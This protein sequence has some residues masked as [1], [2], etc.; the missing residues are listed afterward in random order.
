MTDPS[1]DIKLFISAEQLLDIAKAHLAKCGV[2][3]DSCQVA[4]LSTYFSGTNVKPSW[5]GGDNS[6]EEQKEALAEGHSLDGVVVT[7]GLAPTP[8]GT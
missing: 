2:D 5:D 3:L 4:D 1:T 7:I 8:E 6:Y